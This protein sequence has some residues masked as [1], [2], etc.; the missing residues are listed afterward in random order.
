[1]MNRE[2]ALQWLVDNLESWPDVGQDLPYIKLDNWYWDCGKGVMNVASEY[3]YASIFEEDWISAK[4]PAQLTRDEALAWLVENVKVW[5][6]YKQ[7]EIPPAPND[8]FWDSED[9]GRE[10]NIEL[11]DRK[12]SINGIGKLE[13]EKAKQA[14]SPASNDE[15]WIEHKGG[16]CP[17]DDNVKVEIVLASG[18]KGSADAGHLGC[19]SYGSATIIKYRIISKK[20]ASNK[21]SWDDAPEGANWLCQDASGDWW[22]S[23]SKIN[24]YVFK[25]V[26]WKNPNEFCNEW[27]EKSYQDVP[28]P[29]WRDTL[30]Y[31]PTTKELSMATESHTSL[32]KEWEK[33]NPSQE[34]MVNCIIDEL[35]NNLNRIK[36]ITMNHE[37][38]RLLI[39]CEEIEL[40]ELKKKVSKVLDYYKFNA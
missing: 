9:Y 38:M 33:P 36:E 23:T 29:S 32:P 8:Y 40:A 35:G 25:G 27:C 13:W 39:E 28:N 10:I 4:Q 21:P 20:P 17:V 2:Q 24:P 1:M 6:V 30:E 7:L 15:G 16:E 14:G 3:G 5:P 34:E 22:F 12:N 19:G 11:F 31:R 26:S 37:V 18:S